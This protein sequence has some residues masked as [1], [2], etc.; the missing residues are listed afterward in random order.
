MIVTNAQKSSQ[1]QA[2]EDLESAV[3]LLAA[4]TREIPRPSDTTTLLTILHSVQATLD[5]V[6][7]GLADWHS[8]V[9]H[10]KHFVVKTE[11][12]DLENPGWVRADIALREAEQYGADATAALE[13]AR[14]AN[15]EAI[16]FDE[17]EDDGGS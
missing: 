12:A 7:S 11:H 15:E 8:H 16:W 5:E 6:Y 3:K 9:E 14:S 10:G 13:R 2:A 4:E 17:I 1:I